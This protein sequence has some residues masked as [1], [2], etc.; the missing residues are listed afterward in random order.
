MV[1]CLAATA[2]VCVLLPPLQPLPLPQQP[3]LLLLVHQALRWHPRCHHR[4]HHHLHWR[5]Q[6][7]LVLA[8]EVLA[9]PQA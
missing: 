2:D 1:G 5:Q 6:L 9:A 3:L 7:V 8:P 4:R